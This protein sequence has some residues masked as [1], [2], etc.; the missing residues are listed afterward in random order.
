MSSPAPRLAVAPPLPT[1]YPAYFK[2]YMAEVPVGDILPLL[3]RQVRDTVALLG[4]LNDKQ[5][6]HRYAPGKWSVKEVLGHVIDSERV[7]AYRAM[8]FARGERQSLPG[9]DED[10][11]VAA[12][13]FDARPLPGLLDELQRVRAATVAMF[14]GMADETWNRV[15]TAN[16]R[17]TSVRS[18]PF[19]LAG[20][21]RHHVRILRERYLTRG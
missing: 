7:F 17:A 14:A 9:Y 6:L 2:Q 5:A 3:E 11:W 13:S 21:E 20:H 8:A 15:G 18:M 10:S 1:E 19:I 16:N 12:A 4:G